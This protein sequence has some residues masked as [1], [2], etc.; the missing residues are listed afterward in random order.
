MWS[1]R[2]RAQVAMLEQCEAGRRDFDDDAAVHVLLGNEPAIVRVLPDREPRTR[3]AP[4]VH[5]FVVAPLGLSHP[6]KEVEYQRFNCV[7]HG[8]VRLDFQSIRLG[9]FNH[10]VTV[11]WLG[12]SITDDS[13]GLS[14]N[15]CRYHLTGGCVSDIRPGSAS[16]CSSELRS[17]AVGERGK[18]E[19]SVRRRDRE[20]GGSPSGRS[21]SAE[22]EKI[23]LY[24]QD[25]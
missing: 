1:H 11:W 6:L 5:N 9:S 13:I 19:R 7:K 16:A 17:S 21:R 3:R 4:G 22:E 2:A 10:A 15:P 23:I 24:A 20:G 12:R 18:R 25:A 14:A 8:F